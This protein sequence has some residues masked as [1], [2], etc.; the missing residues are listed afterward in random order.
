MT[1]EMVHN[2]VAIELAYI[3]TKHP[4]FAD[5]CGLMN[6]NIEEQRRNRM[7]DLPSAVPRDKTGGAAQGEQEGGTGNWRGMLKKGEDGQG[8]D[9]S[10]LQSSAS[11]QKGHAVNLLDVPVPVTRKLSAREQRDCEVIER[12]I[13]SYFLIVRKNIQDSVPKAV[14]HF[15]VNHVK[16]SLQSE[17][18]GQLYKSALLDDLLTESED[19]A[20]R[21][22]E[23]ADMLKALQKASQ[24]IAEIRETHLW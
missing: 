23:A 16:D 24:V 21:R 4:D 13:K 22:N 18:V 15:L 10:K 1:N 3:N 14:M 11:T 19:M 7:R 6:N 12:L 5:A 8:D 2:L 17:L 20:Q 9:R